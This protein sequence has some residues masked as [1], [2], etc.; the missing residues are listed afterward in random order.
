MHSPYSPA[1]PPDLA[2][3]LR[4][5]H[6]YRQGGRLAEA[7]ALCRNALALYPRQPDL[8]AQ[9]GG[10]LMQKGDLQAA[11]PLLE[12][13]RKT[14]PGQ[15]QHWLTATQCLLGLGRAKEAKKLISEA[16]RKGL[17]HPLADELL[18]QASGNSGSKT[19]KN[20]PL[21]EALRQLDALFRAG[22]HAEVERLGRELADRH[23]KAFEAWYL[24]GLAALAQGRVQEAVQPFKRAVEL[25]PGMAPAQFNL[26]FALEKLGRMD[27]ALEAYRRTLACDP[28]L[29]DAHNNLGNVLQKLKRHEEALAAYKQAIALR[30][31]NAGYRMN[32]GEALRDLGR[33][34]EAVAAYQAALGINPA[35]VDACVNLSLAL[36]LL[37]RYEESLAASQR[38]A[39]ACPDS[40]E[41]YQNLG[42][43]LS[44]LKR[45]E[46]AVA[47]YRH[48]AGMSPD[49]AALHKELGQA[50]Q[51]SG[52]Y[53][54]ALASLRRALELRPDSDSILNLLAA[55]LL[56]SG[57]YNEAI[58]T[59][60]R[61]L[62]LNSDGFYIHSNIVL[63]LNYQA[64]GAPE[65]LL[66]EARAFG[67]KAASK[68]VPFVRHD[69]PPIPDRRLRVGLVSGDLGRHPVGYFLQNVLESI[70]PDRLEL[71]AYAT[72]ER[73]DALNE[74][75]RRSILHWRD[76]SQQKM[77]DKALA[78]QIRADGIDILIDLAGHTAYNRLPVFAWKAAPV[79]V[80]WLGYLGTSG[81][82]AMD[83]ILADSWALPV[84]E[85]GQ[86]IETP[87]R[88]PESYI[89]FSPPDLPV[90]VGTLPALG[91]GC[92]TFGCFNNL[93]KINDEVVACWA[94]LLQA[95]PDSRLY[96]KT[97]SL[98]APEMREKLVESFG[99]YG[100]AHER[101]R[102]EGKIDSHEEHFRAYHQVD[103][104]LDPFPYPG[105]TT[106][107]EALWMGVPVLSLKGQRFISHQGETILRN[108]GLPQWIAA[109]ADDYVAKA[110]VFAND[111]PALATL[112]AGLRPRLLASPLCD[113]PRFARNFEAA[114][115]GMWR[116]WCEEKGAR[117]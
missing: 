115:R 45:H 32:Q 104:A 30:P 5:A 109:D 106:T 83:Y 103:I 22:R 27:E 87:W 7:E 78:Q 114:L 66:A 117:N 59:Y 13:A 42:H 51:E 35:M 44:Q 8:L 69:N 67:E 55:A 29:P 9:L 89:C 14:A 96:L 50:L 105:I 72:A 25:N 46:E 38:V 43:A 65:M 99:K 12:E 116:K 95:V 97:K 53:E 98:G 92:I 90:E 33:L 113:A 54:A 61:G 107:V 6:M 52:Q 64:G 11:L 77:D 56:D 75:L 74:R 57:R 58:E 39:E 108:V 10:L 41:A 2:H 40:W 70:D 62:A 110:T 1:L 82:A 49:D 91:E 3:T 16:I 85:E 4:T 31:Q 73:K 20:L 84:G 68:A 100:I 93:N 71:F 63:T 36:Y 21:G 26:G 94:G 47:A 34:D 81:L 24:L 23:P 28:R 111:L 76:A 112:R 48:A 19:G 18:R 60:R 15:A 88:L 101:L 17:R 102:L 80:S 79:Q 37:G 86:F